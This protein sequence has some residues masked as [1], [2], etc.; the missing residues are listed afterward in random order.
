MKDGMLSVA[1]ASDPPTASVSTQAKSFDSRTTV[2]NEVRTSAEAASSKIEI[3]RV[4]K[5]SRVMALSDVMGGVLL[6]GVDVGGFDDPRPLDGFGCEEFIGVLGRAAQRHDAELGPARRQRCLMDHLV[7]VFIEFPDDFGRYFGWRRDAIERHRLEA[8][9]P[10]FGH[11]R[12][13]GQGRR[14]AAR[15]YRERAQLAVGDM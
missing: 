6:F 4:H 5:T 1:W 13:G 15:G 2:E 3:S 9:Q 12:H 8:R 11:R 7:D 14:T 10:G